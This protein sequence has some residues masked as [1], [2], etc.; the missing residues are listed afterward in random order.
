MTVLAPN[1]GPAQFGNACTNWTY[2]ATMIGW[3]FLNLIFLDCHEPPGAPLRNGSI[4]IITSSF[5]L[6]VWLDHPS[7]DKRLGAGP[8]KFQ[9]AVF[10]SSPL[11]SKRMYECGLVNLNSCTTPSSSTGFSWSNIANE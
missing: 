3:P 1:N 4:V 9:T 5:G 10:P 11:T 7:R 8:S 6:S 2:G